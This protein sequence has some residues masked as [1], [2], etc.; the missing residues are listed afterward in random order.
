[1]DGGGGLAG[2]GLGGGLAGGGLAG[3]AG[4]EGMLLVVATLFLFDCI[5]SSLRAK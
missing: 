3:V 2:G 4:I 5:R 1:M